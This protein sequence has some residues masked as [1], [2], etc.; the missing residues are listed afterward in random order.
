MRGQGERERERERESN[1]TELV[2]EKD[3]GMD[4]IAWLEAVCCLRVLGA[5][6]HTTHLLLEPNDRVVPDG[7]PCMR[8][9]VQVSVV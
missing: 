8:E 4:P 2:Y 9:C 3:C 7:G 1:R 6:V 5:V